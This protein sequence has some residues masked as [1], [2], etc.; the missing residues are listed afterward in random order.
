[1]RGQSLGVAGRTRSARNQYRGYPL[2][3]S[4]SRR[5]RE[6]L[7]V[8]AP[9]GI[10]DCGG[11]GVGGGNYVPPKFVRLASSKVQIVPL[12]LRRWVRR[13]HRSRAHELNRVSMR[14]A[15]RHGRHQRA[16]PPPLNTPSKPGH[17]TVPFRHS[18][19]WVITCSIELGNLVGLGDVVRRSPPEP[20]LNPTKAIRIAICNAIRWARHAAQKV[21]SNQGARPALP[22]V[23]DSDSA[24]ACNEAVCS[25]PY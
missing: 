20:S 21:A 13:R 19:T 11:W 14:L 1:M 23:R 10:G 25:S 15:Y 12:M 22:A 24:P 4:P 7:S 6:A 8:V 17:P 16:P 18:D 3:G 2:D 5:N 9:G